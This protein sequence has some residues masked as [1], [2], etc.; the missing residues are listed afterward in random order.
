[1]RYYA[2]NKWDSLITAV[3]KATPADLA[4]LSML[5]NGPFRCVSDQISLVQDHDTGHYYLECTDLDKWPANL[6]F[7]FCIAS[8]APIEFPNILTYWADLVAKG[9][10]QTLAYLIA[11]SNDGKPLT[12]LNRAWNYNN[13]CWFD[14]TS[15]WR[16]ILKGEPERL[17][18]FSFRKSP[19]SVAPCNVIWGRSNDFIT[20]LKSSDEEIAAFFDMVPVA[21]KPKPA[22]TN[23]VP[24]T[25]LKG[26]EIIWAELPGALPGPNI[27]AQVNAPHG[28]ILN[29]QQPP[30]PAAPVEF[31]DDFNDD[32]FDDDDDDDDFNDHDEDDDDDEI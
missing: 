14:S 20:L 11:S 5:I 16:R 13:H 8:R 24:F 3:P 12:E 32:D 19:G 6:L 25:G 22:R 15:D 4:Y 18:T 26:G 9:Y 27:W 23:K 29:A 21:P 17:S 2:V 1:M 31:E 30:V 28:Q 7:N 10:D